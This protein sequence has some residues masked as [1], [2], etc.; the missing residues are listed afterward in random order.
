MSEIRNQ[1]IDIAET[2]DPEVSVGV[3][4]PL[5]NIIDEIHDTISSLPDSIGGKMDLATTV[6]RTNNDGTGP[7]TTDENYLAIPNGGVFICYIQGNVTYWMM[8]ISNGVR[9]PIRLA[10]Y[11]D[12]TTAIGGIENGSY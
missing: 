5:K 2:L 7:D 8:R 3:N 9:Y 11:S 10:T 6:V 1:L 4:V 12:I